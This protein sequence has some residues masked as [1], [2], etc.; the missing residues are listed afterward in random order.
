MKTH[1][2]REVKLFFSYQKKKKEESGLCLTKKL[3]ET[4][5]PGG[6]KIRRKSD[7]ARD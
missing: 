5:K 3:K 7:K 6:E 2:K 1:E 4:T